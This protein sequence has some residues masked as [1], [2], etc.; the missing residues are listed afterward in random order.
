[1]DNPSEKGDYETV[2]GLQMS[3]PT[4]ICSQPVAIEA[5]TVSGNPAHKTGDIFQMWV[6]EKSF[7]PLVIQPKQKT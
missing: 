6:M 7:F 1:M 5:K 2:L 4:Q 3:H